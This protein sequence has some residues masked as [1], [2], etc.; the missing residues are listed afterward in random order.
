[1]FY[2]AACKGVIFSRNIHTLFLTVFFIL[3]FAGGKYFNIGILSVRQ[4]RKYF[5]T[6][7][8]EGAAIAQSIY[9]MIAVDHR[10]ENRGMR[11]RFPTEVRDVPVIQGV[12][13]ARGLP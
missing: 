13:P 4:Y 7:F 1:V 9:L 3:F 8:T 12:I 6:Y 5:N 11:V 2:F 10:L